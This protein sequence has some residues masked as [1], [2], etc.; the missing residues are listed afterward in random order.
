[1][2]KNKR[3]GPPVTRKPRAINN[4]GGVGVRLKVF[5]SRMVFFILLFP[6]IIGRKK[7]NT[8][9]KRKETAEDTCDMIN[10]LG[11]VRERTIPTE[12]PPPVGEVSANFCG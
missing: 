3:F 2:R 4:V 7:R 1:M 10:P 11:L 12:R 9:Q 6:S 5:F 8:K